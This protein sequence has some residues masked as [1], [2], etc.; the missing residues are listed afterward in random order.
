[1]N[2]FHSEE[3][4][5]EQLRISL[6]HALKQRQEK[7]MDFPS[8]EK[9]LKE[10]KDFCDFCGE[11]MLWKIYEDEK[12]KYMDQKEKMDSKELTEDT[13]YVMTNSHAII[14]NV[15]RQ[16]GSGKQEQMLTAMSDLGSLR[17]D[18]YWFLQDHFPF[19]IYAQIEK[20][21]YDRKKKNE[22]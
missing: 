16:F 10:N 12:R 22:T 6:T 14:D 2:Q 9:Y 7:T 17:A 5:E 18:I 1:M 4:I 21:I 13:F 8:K 20:K 15:I 19:E 11:E 3:H